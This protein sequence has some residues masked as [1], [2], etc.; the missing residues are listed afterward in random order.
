MDSK[1]CI[2]KSI[3]KIGFSVLLS[4]LSFLAFG[5][6]DK[7]SKTQI[8]S[9]AAYLD[10]LIRAVHPDPFYR[11]SEK[12]Y[13]ALKSRSLQSLGDSC[14]LVEAFKT[15]APVLACLRDS[16]S[17]M[18]ISADPW[19]GYARAGGKLFPLV[20]R[21]MEKR[22][23]LEY[24]CSNGHSFPESTELL[25]INDLPTADLMERILEWY[26]IEEDPDIFYDYIA[27]ELY[28][29]LFYL[30]VLKNDRLRLTLRQGDR[31]E[32]YET[33][34]VSFSA[35][36]DHLYGQQRPVFQYTIGGAD[37]AKVRVGSFMPTEAYFH[38]LDSVFMDIQR[39][40][41]R[42]LVI[43]VRGNAGGSSSAVDALISYLY[44]DS[45]SIYSHID[46][47]VSEGV[48]ERYE[49]RPEYAF[50]MD[51]PVGT[52]IEQPVEWKM[53]DRPNIYS[54]PLEVWLD[55]ATNSGAASFS[56]W[57]SRAG[58]GCL[59]G[60]IGYPPVY[61]GDFLIFKLP[62]TGLTSNISTKKFMNYI[63]VDDKK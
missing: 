4:F 7:F 51:Q 53:S 20:T 58:R 24:D 56:S 57:I 12:E 42:F 39:V 63:N 47:K 61:F 29:H 49:K 14:D 48:K 31:I 17:S 13:E 60:K 16:H 1:N 33:N 27:R 46:L 26:P 9:D 38:F 30:D 15:L 37:T 44:P 19:I 10:S 55:G 18:D 54:G 8:L 21:I 52:L 34:L 3:L 23:W 11:I 35:I 28:V 45:F 43:D 36:R 22:V 6:S 32:A 41:P 50:V 40:T 25:S 5:A 62:N 2:M 59:V